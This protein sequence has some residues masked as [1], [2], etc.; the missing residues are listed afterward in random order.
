MI[1]RLSAA[2]ALALLAIEA[3]AVALRENQLAQTNA[4][5]E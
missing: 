1:H 2:L 5:D 3:Q 4:M